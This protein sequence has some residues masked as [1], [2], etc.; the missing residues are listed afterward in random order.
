M[1]TR[2]FNREVLFSDEAMAKISRRDLESIKVRAFKNK[3]R[4]MRLCL[5]RDIKD[6]LHEMFI[7]HTRDTYVRPHKHL[8]KCES[9]Y[10]VKGSADALMFDERGRILDLLR[11]GEYASGKQFYYRLSQPVYHC[12]IIRSK[13]FIFHEVT[14]GPFKVTDTVFA[15][16]APQENDLAARKKFMEGLEC[17]IQTYRKRR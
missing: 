4:R 1:R 8:K 3:R 6:K 11:L 9:L 13:F 17:A 12:L 7:V 2:M 16:W 5:H 15:T 10:V 14:N